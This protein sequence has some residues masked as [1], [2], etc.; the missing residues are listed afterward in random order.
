MRLMPQCA[1]PSDSI[2]R[3]CARITP[4]ASTPCGSTL[5][6]LMAHCMGRYAPLLLLK[7]VRWTLH[8]NTATK[9]STRCDAPM[10]TV[11]HENGWRCS[12][13][14][15]AHTSRHA[16]RPPVHCFA[17][18]RLTGPMIQSHGRFGHRRLAGGPAPAGWRLLRAHRQ[19][20]R[21]GQR[22]RRPGALSDAC[23]AWYSW[24]VLL[25]VCP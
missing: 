19:R 18:C 16:G 13:R 24:A 14:G 3:K 11:I 23:K 1:G 5:C 8:R 12:S 9:G 6:V 10:H 20:R 25:Y 22:L 17:S 7:G 2:G 21:C 4:T 15:A